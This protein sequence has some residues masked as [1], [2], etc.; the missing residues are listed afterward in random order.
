MGGG[1]CFFFFFF[2]FVQTLT[3]YILLSQQ[4]TSC[5]MLGYTTMG[6]IQGAHSTWMTWSTHN[7][8]TILAMFLFIPFLVPFEVKRMIHMKNL[9]MA[10]MD[11]ESRRQMLLP[12]QTMR[13]VMV[14]QDKR[15]PR[16]V[17]GLGRC[18]QCRRYR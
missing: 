12:V 14:E 16:A 15:G 10:I 17:Q 1:G 18:R 2:S 13:C 8:C 7:F 5:L 3:C 9:A 4:L 11:A 6:G